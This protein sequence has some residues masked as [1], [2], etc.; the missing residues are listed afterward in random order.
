MATS[1]AYSFN[2][3]IDDIITDAYERC[4]IDGDQISAQMW[5][6]AIFSFNMVLAETTNMQLNL[7]EVEPILIPIDI[8]VR[9]Y[10]L[11]TG[12]VD[13]LEVFRR[14]YERPDPESTTSSAGGTAAN[15]SDGNIA[16]S[17]TQAS[18]NGNIQV[19]YSSQTIITM[20]G[21]QANGTATMNLVYEGSNDGAIWATLCA[22][23][24]RSYQDSKIQW[25]LIRTPGSYL[26]YRVR[27]TGGGTIDVREVYFC[28]DE[29]DYILG[30]LS[31]QDY[32]SIST[33]NSQG[34]PNSFYVSRET[35]PYLNIYQPSD[36]T[37][38][39]LFANRIRQIQSVT[40]ATQTMDAPFRF[41]EAITSML[42]VKLAMKRRPDRLPALAEAA[43]ISVKLAQEEDRERVKASFTPNLSAYKV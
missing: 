7:W 28:N 23:G 14:S 21:Y 37:W 17:C 43:R 25:D 20:V 34:T 18:A 8:G 12:T 13:L 41:L 27:E 35:N 29:R 16:T 9:S 31:R 42:A 40:G 2:P 6:S 33:K 26:Y 32:D 4:G 30:R 10:L 24:S 22:P 3:T 5:S 15:A 38:D 11:P 39:M 19:E 36:G 1:G